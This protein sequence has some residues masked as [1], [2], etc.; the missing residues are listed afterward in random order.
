MHK[1][2]FFIISRFL[3]PFLGKGWRRFRLVKSI[4]NFLIPIFPSFVIIEGHKMYLDSK[5]S[6]HLSLNKEYEKAETEIF[7][8]EI[9][10]GNIVIDIG[11]NIGYYTLLAA[12]IVGN[13]GKVFAFEPDPENFKIL[14]KNIDANRYKNVVLVQKVVSDKSKKLKLFLSEDNKAGHKIYGDNTNK[15][16]VI[17]NS[18]TIND[19]LK[20]Q[21]VEV[22]FIKMD[23]EGA[24]GKAF[25]GMSSIMKKNKI[26]IMTEFIPSLLR[27]LDTD[28]RKYIKT[29]IEYGFKIYDINNLNKPA[30][31]EELMQRYDNGKHTNLLCLR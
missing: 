22:D 23:I 12:K 5:D 20:N 29:F 11:A 16:F 18:V 27:D 31:I 28:P 8:K 2:L 26:K 13:K 3:K 1:M 19:F 6:L 10:E 14:K 24:E 30:T 21:D 4:Y 25:A 15:N 17:V 7:K 9:K